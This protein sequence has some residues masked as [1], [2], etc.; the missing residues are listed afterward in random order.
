[1]NKLTALIICACIAI[2]A[3][4][5]QT[6]QQALDEI[7]R[8]EKLSAQT[9]EMLKAAWEAGRTETDNEIRINNG[10]SVIADYLKLLTAHCFSR[11]LWFLWFYAVVWRLRGRFLQAFSVT[12]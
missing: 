12:L 6:R 8:M 2:S 5:A 1:M 3:A 9:P 11:W 7:A 4:S 10:G